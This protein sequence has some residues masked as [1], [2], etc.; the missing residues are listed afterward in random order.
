MRLEYLFLLTIQPKAFS[1][2]RRTILK[3]YRPTLTTMN[4]FTCSGPLGEHCKRVV[5]AFIEY[6]QK[7]LL[8]ERVATMPTYA[9]RW[10]GISGSVE[11]DEWPVDAVWRELEEETCLS[12]P[13]LKLIKAGLP[14]DIQDGEREFRV[15][16]FLFRLMQL[17]ANSLEESI[18]LN[19]ENR[20]FQLVDKNELLTLAKQ[21]KTVPKLD[22]TFFRVVDT[23]ERIPLQWREKAKLLQQNTISGASEL[24]IQVAE[25]VRDGAPGEWIAA[26]RPTMVSLV[27]IA[28]EV[29]MYPQVD[30]LTKLDNAIRSVVEQTGEALIQSGYRNIA[31][32]SSSSTVFK[33]LEWCDRNNYLLYVRVAESLP[34]GEG[35]LFYERVKKL[36]HVVQIKV[37]NQ[38]L[39]K[40]KSPHI[41]LIITGA[42]AV[43]SNGD[44]INKIGTKQLVESAKDIR[45]WVIC[46]TFKL[47]KDSVPPPMEEDLFQ[48]I[49]KT[50]I[51]RLFINSDE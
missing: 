45:W 4:W 17:P 35:R 49:P 8:F 12:S 15:H 22:D 14:L 6:N 46:D 23:L 40:D 48:V 43:L 42:D 32:F 33:L 26:L 19:S 11:Q 21:G 38:L 29:S 27:N 41:Q 50:F 44:V 51:D 13:Y 16:P 31:T 34:G 47:W 9:E 39:Q 25:C 24:A 37:D 5:T 10:S 20:R 1:S 7:Y 2:S 30:V 28:R 18:R 36:R 3:Y